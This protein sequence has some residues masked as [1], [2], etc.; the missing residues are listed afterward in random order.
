[1]EPWLGTTTE[2][3]SFTK[4]HTFQEFLL[5]KDP[6]LLIN[7]RLQ[8]DGILKKLFD[9][10]FMVVSFMPDDCQPCIKGCD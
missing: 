7:S 4:N 2:V 10:N 9:P 3:R 8:S 5:W 1:M 6:A